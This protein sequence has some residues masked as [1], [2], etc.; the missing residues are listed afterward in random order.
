MTF[1]EE[2][3]KSILCVF[4]ILVLTGRKY[5]DESLFAQLN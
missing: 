4:T 2:T 3:F 1:K 5:D